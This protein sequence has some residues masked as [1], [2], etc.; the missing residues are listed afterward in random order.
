MG[1][2]NISLHILDVLSKKKFC[3][4]DVSK[5]FFWKTFIAPS[6]KIKFTA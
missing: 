3:S 1:A 6:V 5:I 2:I 4:I